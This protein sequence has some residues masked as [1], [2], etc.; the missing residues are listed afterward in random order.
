MRGLA[1][2]LLLVVASP[3]L[4][5]KYEASMD[6][7]PVGGLATVHEA[8]AE[9][10]TVPFGG[11][12]ARFGYGLE[13]WLEIDA[14][15]AFAQLARAHY[16]NV[17]VTVDRGPEMPADIDRMTR[18][19][20]ASIGALFRFGVELIP[21]VYIGAGMQGRWRDAAMLSSTAFV[22]DGYDTDLSLDLTVT[23]RVGLDYRPHRRWVLGA[24]VGVTHA[25]AI[26][27]PG[28]DALEGTLAASYYWYPPWR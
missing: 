19:G 7:H 3:A 5:D 28:L 23:A 11:L 25:F 9:A 18:V 12:A 1:V 27:A 8:A 17:Q 21:T 15:V 2:V 4:A 14:E 6:V 20:R 22:P 16:E 10:V 13:H 24:S 26:G